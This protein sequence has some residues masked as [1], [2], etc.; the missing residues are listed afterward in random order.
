[1]TDTGCMK[2]TTNTKSLIAR[3]VVAAAAIG[4]SMTP[5]ARAVAADPCRTCR[6]CGGT[7]AGMETPYGDTGCGP[8][9]CLP[10]THCDPCDSCNRW[11]GCNGGREMPDVLAPWQLPPGRGF[12]SAEQ[13]GYDTRGTCEECLAQPWHAALCAWW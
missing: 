11:R 13:V 6:P 5:A 7:A 4:L 12:Q 10:P 1:M 8:R 2:R 9:Y 3:V